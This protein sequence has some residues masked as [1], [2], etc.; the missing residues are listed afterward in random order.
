MQY[1]F[2]LNPAIEEGAF[3]KFLLVMGKKVPVIGYKDGCVI[4]ELPD[5]SEHA[6]VSMYLTMTT[7]SSVGVIEEFNHCK[8]FEYTDDSIQ[9]EMRRL[10]DKEVYVLQLSQ[11]I[12][13]PKVEI[14]PHNVNLEAL[15][16][17]G[18]KIWDSIM[19]KPKPVSSLI[20][21]LKSPEADGYV[22]LPNDLS[23][24][25]EEAEQRIN[26]AFYTQVMV[27]AYVSLCKKVDIN[28]SIKLSNGLNVEAQSLTPFMGLQNTVVGEVS[29]RLAN[30]TLVDLD[31][32]MYAQQYL[33]CIL[34]LQPFEYEKGKVLKYV[35]G[36]VEHILM[37][38][39]SHKSNQK[40]IHA[41]YEELIGGDTA[42]AW[43]EEN[44]KYVVEAV[45]GILKQ[46]VIDG[47]VL[48]DSKEQFLARISTMQ[49]GD[50]TV[51]LGKIY[52]KILDT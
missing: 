2:Q 17:L 19:V 15:V 9:S 30:S 40:V 50:Y 5:K 7:G 12:P 8:P 27:N 25:K 36:R 46:M 35:L 3:G 22:Y 18:I 14:V 45:L 16:P 41:L 39:T 44:Q 42:R 51:D 10:V 33:E 23:F 32:A 1:R 28:P 4:L 47:A 31:D 38:R 48:E 49:M 26:N 6:Q 29:A 43:G 52:S 21:W 34:D 11:Q 20:H 13:E 24:S 37:G